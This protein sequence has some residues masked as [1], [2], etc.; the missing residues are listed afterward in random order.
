MVHEEESVDFACH[1]VG[2]MVGGG[3]EGNGDSEFVRPPKLSLW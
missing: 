2:Y 1:A 3:G